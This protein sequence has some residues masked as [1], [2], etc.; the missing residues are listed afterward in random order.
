MSCEVCRSITLIN[1]HIPVPAIQRND[2]EYSTVGFF[3]G[4]KTESIPIDFKKDGFKPLWEYLVRNT[5]KN[6]GHY[7]HQN[8]FVF[9]NDSWNENS[10]ECFWAEEKNQQYPLTFV[11]FLQLQNYGTEDHSIE[12]MCRC[13]SKAVSDKLSGHGIAYCYYTVDKND[14][15]VCIKCMHYTRAV[16]TIKNLHNI[17][18]QV[19]YSYSVFSISNKILDELSE[20]DYPEIYDQKISSISLKGIVNSIDQGINLDCKYRDLCDRLAKQLFRDG[21]GENKLYDILG[22]DDFR[23]IARQVSLGRLL[24][25]YASGGL[26]CYT[27]RDFGFYL[28]SS[29]LV[30]NT[31]TPYPPGK[32]IEKSIIK[33]QTQS[34]NNPQKCEGLQGQLNGIIKG[35]GNFDY[36]EGIEEEVSYLHAIWQL[37][38]SL[39]VLEVAPTKK[40]DFWTLYFPLSMLIHI[41]DEKRDILK[42]KMLHEFIHKISMTFHGTLRTDIQ[43][44]QIRDFNVIVHYAPAKLRAFYSLWAI[45][46]KDFYNQLSIADQEN[47]GGD[48]GSDI[49]EYSFIFSPGMFKEISVMQLYE[50][51]D[52]N[53]KLLLITSPELYLYLNGWTP[54]I[55]AHEVS[56]FVGSNPRSRPKRHDMW[57]QCCIRA[58]VLEMES[59]RYGSLREDNT[60]LDLKGQLEVAISKSNIYKDLSNQMQ[61]D[62][63]AVR[64][65]E[66]RIAHPFHS[67]NSRKIIENTFRR[68][69]QNDMEHLIYSDSINIQE[70]IERS[71]GFD[72]KSDAERIALK[73][74]L[75][76]VTCDNGRC[77]QGFVAKFQAEW[78][79][80]LLDIFKY[81]TVEGYADLMM[82]LS[83][84]I[85]PERYLRSFIDGLIKAKSEAKSEAKK[86]TNRNI[87]VVRIG[88]VIRAVETIVKQEPLLFT[89]QFVEAWS[90]D[91]SRNLAMVLPINEKVAEMAALVY[92][93]VDTCSKNDHLEGIRKYKAIY[94]R[95]KM[96]F[97]NKEFDFLRDRVIWDLMSTY[98]QACAEAYARVLKADVDL[99]EMQKKLKGIYETLSGG[100]IYD[101]AQEIENFLNEFEEKEK[102]SRKKCLQ[103]SSNRV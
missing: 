50:D 17:G 89:T 30:I 103:F 14:F 92:D 63:K 31:A 96:G 11:V 47:T 7:S 98:L 2:I 81:L 33:A 24:E 49:H 97:I 72:K 45:R 38:Q 67:K 53:R 40:Y 20:K 42:S 101:A 88:M 16:E 52:Q 79:D 90:G 68:T 100:T 69:V 6:Q 65:Y 62:E 29:N 4:M 78:L 3:D 46:I 99:R 36:V 25:Q 19:I 56:H 43:F 84:E 9:G 34:T 23:F 41:L 57:L 66:L 75:G 73:R 8:V 37:L 58:L 95:S 39:K 26:L 32:R 61:E 102:E 15:V 35:K 85:L 83:L 93:Y 82:V 12:T 54:L 48:S 86:E 28:F 18:Q 51:Y 21:T 77:M 55:L 27:K 80:Q 59:F 70:T 5:K 71:I 87:L 94:D 10:D 22:G 76:K 74:I 1:Y 13:F 60:G 91:V 44:F 64:E